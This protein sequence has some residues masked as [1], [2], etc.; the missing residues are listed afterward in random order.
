MS[1]S[2]QS[3]SCAQRRNYLLHTNS[4][5]FPWVAMASACACARFPKRGG[6]AET[7]PIVDEEFVLHCI[8]EYDEIF[9]HGSQ[10]E[11][12]NARL[13]LGIPHGL[14]GQRQ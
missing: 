12:D 14:M 4:I 1:A 7:L 10:E 3:L 11:V 6:M 8:E 9:Q 13:R 5:L 2:L